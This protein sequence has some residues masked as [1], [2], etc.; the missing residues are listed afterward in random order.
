MSSFFQFTQGTESHHARPSDSS[1][2][3]GRFRA[4]P[5][6]PGL[7]QNRYGQLGLFGD[8]LAANGGGR[9][10][11]HVGYGVLVAA[12]LEAAQQEE[13]EEGHDDHEDNRPPRWKRS[14]RAYTLDLW[15]VPRHSAVRKVV[16]AWWS[17]Y[18]LL[19]LLPAI[20]V[21]QQ[22]PGGMRGDADTVA[23]AV[24]WCSV[25]FPQ[26]PLKDRDDET[27]GGPNGEPQD[28]YKTPGHGEARV[29]VNFWFFLFVYYGFYNLTALIWITK[30]FNLYN[31]NW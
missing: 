25:P 2:L 9:G 15:V 20:L 14:W 10:S 17:R 13:E 6:R 23:K 4:V 26:Y 19:V 18:G 30:V 27:V 5:P 21:R 29:R 11:V 7:G 22:G 16:D 24:A 1:P 28:G 8:R 12:E 31:L 3:L